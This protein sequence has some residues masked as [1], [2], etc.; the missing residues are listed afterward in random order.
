[1]ISDKV[2]TYLGIIA[3]LGGAVAVILGAA[4]WI[5]RIS[6]VPAKLDGHVSA[7]TTYHKVSDSTTKGAIGELH[8]H[9]TDLEKLLES[10]VRGEC[11]ENP[12]A[13]LA[14]QGLLAKCR[15]LGI[16]R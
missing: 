14:R 3:A 4:G 13:D 1:M 6:D 11:I 5:L 9:T 10:L 2:K 15:Q 8:G 7:E 16:D 12:R